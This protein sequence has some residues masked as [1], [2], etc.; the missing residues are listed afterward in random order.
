MVVFSRRVILI[1]SGTSVLYTLYIYIFKSCLKFNKNDLYSYLD[2]RNNA[3]LG[4]DIILLFTVNFT[5]L[6]I[7]IYKTLAYYTLLHKQV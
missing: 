7:K 5:R 4:K 6:P 3:L 2:S 1:G